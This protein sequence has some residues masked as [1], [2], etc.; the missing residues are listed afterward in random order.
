MASTKL[1]FLYHRLRAQSFYFL[2]KPLPGVASRGWTAAQSFALLA[3]WLYPRHPIFLLLFFR[4]LEEIVPS[5]APVSQKQGEKVKAMGDPQP[6]SSP[7]A[8]TEDVIPPTPYPPPA[9]RRPLIEPPPAL[10]LPS[11]SRPNPTRRHNSWPRLTRKTMAATALE[12]GGRAL[13]DWK[14]GRRKTMARLED[15]RLEEVYHGSTRRRWQRL[16]SKLVG[17]RGLQRRHT[18]NPLFCLAPLTDSPPQQK[19]QTAPLVVQRGILPFGER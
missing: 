19:R 17:E 14:T 12:I 4:F 16:P 7:S 2:Y 5:F 10:P 15:G 1:I 18:V 3:K 9:L 13:E 8:G 11:G 6:S